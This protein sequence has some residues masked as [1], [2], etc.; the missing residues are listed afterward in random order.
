MAP[1]HLYDLEA[2]NGEPTVVHVGDAQIGAGSFGLIAGPPAGTGVN[3]AVRLAVALADAGATLLHDGT[4]SQTD[5]YARA[6]ADRFQV[7]SAMREATGLPIAIGLTS[8]LDVDAVVE[9]ADVIQVASYH[10]QNYA[11]LRE[12][13]TAGKTVLLRRGLASLLDELL[14]AAE[15][16]LAG[17]N[18]SVLLCERGIRSYER[19]YES[20]LDVAAV[21]VLKE[22]THLPVVVDPSEHR[23]PNVIRALA[24]AAAAAG[25]DGVILE[26]ETD[27]GDLLERVLMAAQIG[28]G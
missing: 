1:K 6:P 25:A 4:A 21:A 22:R 10:M 2:T 14:G 13:G 19:A 5:P 9:N 27:P 8:A 24:L 15:Y 26:V 18:A 20:V 16:I 11:L 7:A 12:L 17:G 3:D 23:R 28:R